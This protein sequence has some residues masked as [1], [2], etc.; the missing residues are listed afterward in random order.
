MSATGEP[1]VHAYAFDWVDEPNLTFTERLA[2][3]TKSLAGESD[4]TV[5]T[6]TMV[7]SRGSMLSLEESYLHMGYEG[8]MLRTPNGLYKNGRSTLNQGWL[9][10]LKRFTDSDAQII[11]L[12]ERMHN[13]NEAKLNELGNKSRSSHKANM[14]PTG[15]LGAFQVRDIHTGVEFEIGTG[16]G[17]ALRAEVWQNGHKYLGGFLKYKSF[18]S[19]GYDKPRFPVFL[20][21]RDVRD[22][23]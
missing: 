22:I 10:K 13:A 20:G 6:Q 5:L 2:F 16:M 1:A 11:G 21:F 17:D 15:T 8:L 7:F 3:L 23:S 4:V 14:I 19:G 18:P 9:M 12:T